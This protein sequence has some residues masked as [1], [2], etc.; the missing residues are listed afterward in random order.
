MSTKSAKVAGEGIMMILSPAKTLDLSPF[1]R[2]PTLPTTLPECNVAKTLEV[3]RALKSRRESELA[4]LLKLSPNLG[5]TAYGYWQNFQDE[6]TDNQNLKPCVYAFTGVAYQGLQIRE[7]T[8]D[9][10]L[11]LQDNLR[12]IDPLY[13]AL[14]PLD[15]IQPY[16]LEM[17][18][19]NVFA[20]D[21]A[22]KLQSFWK[23][24]V[25]VSLAKDLEKR[26]GNKVVLN[27]ASDE[28]SSAV[29]VS[30]LPD[31]TR[32]VK[33]VFHHGGRVLTVHAKRARGLM[34]RFVAENQCHS[35]EQVKKFNYEGY[36]LV[37]SQSDDSCLVFDRP[38]D[39]TSKR[40]TAADDSKARK[41]LKS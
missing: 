21:K 7:C 23:D 35:L 28:Y 5:K 29:D 13:G 18:T 6:P 37:P 3:V 27:I 19:K 1:L 39:Y 12:I 40:S 4:K 11:Y 31:G 10:V 22:L 17:A 33:V 8:N 25:T 38:K 20:T 36:S 9:T 16:R 14:R 26:R 34:A 24:S 41:K 2:S 15:E 30:G 32:V